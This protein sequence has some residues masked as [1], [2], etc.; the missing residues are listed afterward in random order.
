MG[1]VGEFGS[2]PGRLRPPPQ[3]GT[4]GRGPADRSRENVEQLRSRQACT[5]PRSVMRAPGTSTSIEPGQSNDPGDIAARGMSAS[6]DTEAD[7]SM[8]AGSSA[9][10]FGAHSTAQC[11]PIRLHS[12]LAF[13]PLVGATLATDTPPG[14]RPQVVTPRFRVTTRLRIGALPLAAQPR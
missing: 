12:R 13:T 2:G 8:L 7:V 3:P 10:A 14:S 4:D 9:R 5:S 1:G 6:N 11:L